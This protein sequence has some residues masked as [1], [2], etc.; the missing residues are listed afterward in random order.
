MNS[1]RV[2]LIL[3]GLTTLLLVA[4]PAGAFGINKLLQ[5]KA[6]SLV[7]LKLE[8]QVLAGQ[9]VD[10]TKA[11]KDVATY[12]DLN[13][14]AKTIV[15][16]D[17]DQ[18]EAV[19][20]ISNLAQDSGIN[21]LSSITFPASTLGGT[22]SSNA[23]TS[24][25]ITTPQPATTGKNNLTQLTPVKGVGGVYQL[26][27]TISQAND[28]SV[29]Y[30]EFTTFLGKLE[31]NRRTAQVTSITLTPDPNHASRVSFTLIINEFIKP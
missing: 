9:Q 7:R 12:S 31:Q 10:L 11:K 30:S 8:D 3:I 15:P 16:Q 26:Q 21:Q 6:D 22:G 27:I 19:L 24:T 20:E 23:S 14:I 17:K 5:S 29:P 28:S 18:A 13:Q 25:S 4:L 2:H 1:K